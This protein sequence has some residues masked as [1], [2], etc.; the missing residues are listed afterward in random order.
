MSSSYSSFAT[1]AACRMN[2]RRLHRRESLA[3]YVLCAG[4]RPLQSCEHFYS[5]FCLRNFVMK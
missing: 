4:L 5:A 1:T 3:S 2:V